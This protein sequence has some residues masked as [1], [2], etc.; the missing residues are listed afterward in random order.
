M[1]KL[2]IIML[3]VFIFT[4]ISLKADTYDSNDEPISDLRFY[5]LNVIFNKVERPLSNYIIT[6]DPN[7]DI[8]NYTN[9]IGLNGLT[10]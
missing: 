10:Q 2:L 6:Q 5:T 3:G 4:P 9:F 8:L 1:K 7:F